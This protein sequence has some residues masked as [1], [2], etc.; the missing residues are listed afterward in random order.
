M[1]SDKF[2]ERFW[3]KVDKKEGG[4][5]DWTASCTPDG[6]GQVKYDGKVKRPHRISFEIYLGR[7]ILEG[8]EIAH[9]PLICHNRKCVNPAHLTEKTPTDNQRDRII[10]GT[11]SM[12]EKMGNSK[13]TEEQIIAIRADD[14]KKCV[15]A[16]DYSV[17]AWHI[18]RIKTGKVWKH[19]ICTC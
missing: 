16:K 6:Y 7:T 15:I 10:D 9:A 13:L 1:Y 11:D 2:L 14:R 18:T 8:M 17:S 12:G 4:C 3:A 5:W 19:V